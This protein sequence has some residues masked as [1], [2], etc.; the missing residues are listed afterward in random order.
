M[1]DWKYMVGEQ[2]Y[3]QDFPIFDR[4]TKAAFDG[5]NITSA[6]ISIKDTKLADLAPPLNNQAMT[7]PENNPLKLRY[8]ITTSN[9]PQ[10]P[11]NYIAVITLNGTGSLVRKTYEIDLRV[12][13][14]A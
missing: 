11:G 12:Y 5:T 6:T 8:A 13:T 9:M 7:I 4:G 1:S 10:T 2:N 3:S 14:G